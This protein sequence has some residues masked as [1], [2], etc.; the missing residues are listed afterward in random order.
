MTIRGDA[1]PFFEGFEPSPPLA[2]GKDAI[3][4]ALIPNFDA[5]MK[6]HAASQRLSATHGLTGKLLKPENLHITLHPLGQ[7]DGVPAVI[8]ELA[9]AI[10]SSIHAAPFEVAFNA[11]MSFKRPRSLPFVLCGDEGV[12]GVAALQKQFSER[13][14]PIIKG[15][16]QNTPHMTLLYDEKLVVRQ[17]MEIVRF[18]VD[19]FVLIHSKIGQGR[20]EIL[21]RWP[22]RS[23]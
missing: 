13:L 7:Y 16:G 15:G 19:S 18:S 9:A 12:I 11:A 3:F 5:A 6:I 23:L 8:E 21:N 17:P 1:Q 20:H 4:F 2:Q 10:A 14:K 22:L